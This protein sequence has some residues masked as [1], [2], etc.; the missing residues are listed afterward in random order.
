MTAVILQSTERKFHMSPSTWER[1]CEIR[2]WKRIGEQWRMKIKG[3]DC[4]TVIDN[5]SETEKD[6]AKLRSH[7]VPVPLAMRRP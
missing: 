5:K 2:D 1:K 3:N 4:K 6:W 7:L